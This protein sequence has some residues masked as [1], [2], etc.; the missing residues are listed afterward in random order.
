MDKLSAEKY[1]FF[2]KSPSDKAV[3][4]IHGITGTPAEMNYLGKSLNKAGYNVLCN[5]LP[6]HCS[7][8]GELRKVTWQEI[9][10]N[11]QNDLDFLNKQFLNVSI[12][13]LSMGALVG[14][15]LSYKFPEKVHSLVALAPT[16]FYDGWAVHKGRFLMSIGWHIPFLRNR[17]NIRESWPYGLKDEYMRN[18]IERFY[19]NSKAS[20]F[21]DKVLLFG[22]PFFPIACLYQHN[23]FAKFIKNE[24]PQVK[25]PILIIHAKEDDMVSIKN[26]EYI[27]KNIGSSDKKMIILEDSY[28]M[29][30]IDKEKRKVSQETIDFLNKF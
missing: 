23:L 2:L 21:N 4:L 16:I 6:R 25:N 12:V 28:H 27:Y 24:I 26:S 5:A 1:N 29:I 19:K 10:K 8:L 22:S 11:A 14:I 13:G 20:E 9:V 3:L 7:S 15:H 17:I 18:V 30:T